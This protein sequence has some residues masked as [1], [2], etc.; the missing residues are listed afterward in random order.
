MKKAQLSGI[1]LMLQYASML[2]LYAFCAQNEANTP[3]TY[4]RE[5]VLLDA[6][7]IFQ[8]QNHWE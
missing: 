5:N 6:G 2:D 1:I 3:T 7:H 4:G 8:K